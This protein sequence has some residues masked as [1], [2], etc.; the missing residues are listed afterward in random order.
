MGWDTVATSSPSPTPRSP[1]RAT[2][3]TS[4]PSPRAR[5]STSLRP[6]MP[7]T[8]SAPRLSSG[9]VAAVQEFTTSLFAPLTEPSS[10]SSAA[11]AAALA[12]RTS[13]TSPHPVVGPRRKRAEQRHQQRHCCAV[14]LDARTAQPPQDHTGHLLL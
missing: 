9:V 7:A 11:A 5:T 14:D 10:P 6:S 12:L 4:A 1:S 8:N 3:T 2:P 13:A